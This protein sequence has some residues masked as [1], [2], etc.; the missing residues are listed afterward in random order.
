MIG[1]RDFPNKTPTINIVK[2]KIIVSFEIL[3]RKY[4]S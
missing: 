3:S 1:V 2:P 4:V